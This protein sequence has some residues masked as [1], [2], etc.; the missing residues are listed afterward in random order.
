M[1][2]VRHGRKTSVHLTASWESHDSQ[3]GLQ[4]PPTSQRGLAMHTQSHKVPKTRPQ[5]VRVRMFALA[6][7]ALV[8]LVCGPPAALASVGSFEGGDGDQVSADC[9]AVLDWQCLSPSQ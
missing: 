9:A 6:T 1:R 8:V 3:A 4:R 2:Q 7:L 5:R